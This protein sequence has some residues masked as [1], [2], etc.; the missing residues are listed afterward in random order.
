LRIVSHASLQRRVI[1]GC[2]LREEIVLV[3]R[4]VLHKRHSHDLFLGINLTIIRRLCHMP[5]VVA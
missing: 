4:E 3:E 2:E 5:T 1:A